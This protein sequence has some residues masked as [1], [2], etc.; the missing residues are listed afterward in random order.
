M[1]E[2]DA[3]KM[4]KMTAIVMKLYDN[5]MKANELYKEFGLTR[6]GK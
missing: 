4:E 2:R 1:E 3:R 6:L 5:A